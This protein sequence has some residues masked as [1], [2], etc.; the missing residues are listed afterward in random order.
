MAKK[1]SLLLFLF[2]SFLTFYLSDLKLK[3]KSEKKTLFPIDKAS[4]TTLFIKNGKNSYFLFKKNRKWYLKKPLFYPADTPTID[5]LVEE[6]KWLRKKGEFEREKN[7]RIY[8]FKTPYNFISFSTKRRSYTLFLGSKN[9]TGDYIYVTTPNYPK[10]IYIVD[11]YIKSELLKDLSDLVE[12][13]LFT[14]DP[15]EVSEVE[16]KWK[17]VCKKFKEEKNGW[18]ALSSKK[19]IK[20]S[21]FLSLLRKI[22]FLY[23]DPAGK[24]DRVIDSLKP[25]GFIVL[26]QKEDREKVFFFEK[27]GKIYAKRESYTL[28]FS[29][30]REE[31]YDILKEIKKI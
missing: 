19:T 23:G 15:T 22:C 16:I 14:K 13:R 12:R 24:K 17:G 29:V 5:T 20:S 26:A 27:D 8:G 1:I 9:P 18:K 28:T 7:P 2:L 21:K 25:K 6:I 31:F 3:A 30:D 11:S 4:I 10:K